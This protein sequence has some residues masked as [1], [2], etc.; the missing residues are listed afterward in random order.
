MLQK[1]GD[2]REYYIESRMKGISYIQ[3]KERRIIGLLAY[4]VETVF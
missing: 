3:L 2:M 4:R 1:A